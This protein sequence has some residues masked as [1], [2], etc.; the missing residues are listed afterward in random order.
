MKKF[1]SVFALAMLLMMGSSIAVFAEEA[2]PAP[3]KEGI[4]GMDPAVM[5]KMKTLTSPSEAH[6]ALE[7]FVGNWKYTGKFWMTPDAPAQEMTGTAKHEMIFGGRFLK[8]EI[9]GP[10]M[11]QTFNG[12][13][14]TG[15]DN[16]KK[17]YESVWIDS[18]GTGIMTVAGQYDAAA[19]SLN[20][21]GANS[22]PLTGEA[23][24]KGRSEWKTLDSD[25]STYSSY[26]AGPDGKE[27]KS[28][29]LEYTRA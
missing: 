5:E 7:A 10:W 20:Q 4:P 18:V 28:M 26:I 15:Y 16:I 2:A 21:S 17:E 27:F 25:H 23:A 3:G 14:Y 19:S 13:G 9:E 24:R 8:Q 12:I 1:Q 29:E 6:K 11:G 22:C